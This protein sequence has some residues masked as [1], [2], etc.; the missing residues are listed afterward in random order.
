MREVKVNRW[1]HGT[2]I[3]A[4]ESRRQADRRLTFRQKLEWNSQALALADK[5]K[6]APKKHFN[7]K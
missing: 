6:D 2:W 4:E 1:Q 3:G 7:E 5:L